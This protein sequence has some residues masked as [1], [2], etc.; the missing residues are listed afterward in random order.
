[1]CNG[2]DLLALKTL[3]APKE[4]TRYTT[5]V[6]RVLFTHEEL[7]TG[8]LPP[9]SEHGKK[10]EFDREKLAVLRSNQ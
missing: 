2:I 10:T 8:M 3:N 9:I 7:L 6:A 4:P 5:R 1:M